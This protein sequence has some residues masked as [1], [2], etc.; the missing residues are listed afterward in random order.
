MVGIGDRQHEVLDSPAF[1]R[2]A[3]ARPLCE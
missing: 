1:P 2:A 3:G